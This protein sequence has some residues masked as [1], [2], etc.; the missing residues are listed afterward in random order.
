MKAKHIHLQNPKKQTNSFNSSVSNTK[1][2]HFIAS[3]IPKIKHIH[4][5]TLQNDNFHIFFPLGVKL[6]KISHINSV[7]LICIGF[8]VSFIVP[9]TYQSLTKNIFYLLNIFH[10]HTHRC[11]EMIWR[12]RVDL[13]KIERNDWDA[14]CF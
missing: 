1:K 5:F 9:H 3:I 8:Y 2:N 7:R 10:T 6:L 4:I 14:K 11:F 12:R 13:F